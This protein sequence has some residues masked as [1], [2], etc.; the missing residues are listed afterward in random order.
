MAIWA[1]SAERKNLLNLLLLSFEKMCF[2]VQT[3]KK[4][5]FNSNVSVRLLCD[6]STPLYEIFSDPEILSVIAS[7]DDSLVLKS[8]LRIILIVFVLCQ[9]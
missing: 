9:Y 2:Y 8:Q 7:I 3:I 1:V 6:L 4:S 5:D